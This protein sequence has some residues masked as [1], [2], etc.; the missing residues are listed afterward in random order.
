MIFLWSRPTWKLFHILTA[1]IIEEKFDDTFKND[2]ITLFTKI[3][4]NIPCMM[5]RTHASEKMTKINRD[6]ITSARELELFFYKFHNEV[7]EITNTKIFP[8]NK[9]VKYK[10][11]SVKKII[12][13]FKH[14][15]EN[16]YRNTEL[17]KEY[18]EWTKSNQDKFTLYE[19]S[20]DKKPKDEKSKDKKPKDEKPKDEKPKDKKPKDEK[21]K[22][23][24][25]KNKKP[26]DKKPKDEKPKNK[27][28]KNKK[29]K[30]KKPKDK[31]PKNKSKDKKPKDKK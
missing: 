3:C 13:E 17:L 9:L 1:N 31:K 25:S 20:K 6:E 22:D 29:P 27:K 14:V 30:D 10:S 15:L 26:K 21:P 4:N 16:Y 8:E 11:K 28:P 7:N 5:C 19:K 24:K 23:K 2:C 12:K 18:N